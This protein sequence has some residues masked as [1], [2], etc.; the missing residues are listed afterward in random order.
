MSFRKHHHERKMGALELP[1]VDYPPIPYTGDRFKITEGITGRLCVHFQ[2]GNMT[3]Y[4]PSTTNVQDVIN[5]CE[6][7]QKLTVYDLQN[8]EHHINSIYVRHEKIEPVS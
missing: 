2:Q 4:L 3:W 5:T 6:A 7:M 8:C 1:L